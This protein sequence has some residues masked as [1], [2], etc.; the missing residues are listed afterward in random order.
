DEV[1]SQL[2]RA[3]A[4][5]EQIQEARRLISEQRLTEARRKVL[6]AIQSDPEGSDGPQLLE[7][8]V[9]AI[10]RQ[11]TET[12]IE[13]RLGEAKP[14][15]HS[16]AVDDAI[17]TLRAL[18]AE[19]PDTSEVERWLLRAH[20]E[21]N[22]A[23]RLAI[24]QTRLREARAC[25]DRE[26]F[27]V[28]KVLVENL[29]VEF[30]EEIEVRGLLAEVQRTLERIRAIEET[31]TRCQEFRAVSKF[32]EAITALDQALTL[33]PAD[34]RLLA[35]RSEIAAELRESQAAARKAQ[36]LE[37]AHWLLDCGRPD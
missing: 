34:A 28:A 17:A 10:I 5:A 31:I 25:L 7:I 33:Y 30:P 23:E 3:R 18:Q 24:L 27:S 2:A 22:R 15:W 37:E 32:E 21:K 35:L 8:I 9:A 6:E 12:E 16:N 26:Q 29:A 14:L 13:R 20:N 11:E 4:S 36:V 1:Q 19:Y